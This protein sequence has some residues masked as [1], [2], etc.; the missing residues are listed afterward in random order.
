[1][2]RDSGGGL[3]EVEFIVWDSE[4]GLQEV[5]FTRWTFKGSFLRVIS[6]WNLWVV[7]DH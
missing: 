3:E 6:G 5:D 2:G 7:L 1:M 4:C